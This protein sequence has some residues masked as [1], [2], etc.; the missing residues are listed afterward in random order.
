MGWLRTYLAPRSCLVANSVARRPEHSTSVVAGR[1]D[2]RVYIFHDDGT[3]G[4]QLVHL[5]IDRF[6]MF[7]PTTL[8]DRLTD[9]ATWR[10]SVRPLDGQVLCIDCR[11]RS[12][13]ISN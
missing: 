5:T 1:R 2:G 3:S 9:G 12:G 8:C 13:D 7:T 10:M 6:V 11:R 4:R